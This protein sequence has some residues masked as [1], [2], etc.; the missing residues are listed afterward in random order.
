MRARSDALYGAGASAYS[1]EV[2]GL[3]LPISEELLNALA[4]Q[5]AERVREPRRWA[6][7]EATADV[8]AARR[9]PFMLRVDRSGGRMRQRRLR[10]FVFCAAA[11]LFVSATAFAA[12]HCRPCHPDPFGTKLLSVPGSIDTYS[13]EG[14]SVRGVHDGCWV[15]VVVSLARGQCP[16]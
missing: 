12:A 10:V 9:E 16:S 13:V 4:E 5:V 1:K 3:A 6:E 11:P 7:I 14:G 15:R 8:K 2:I